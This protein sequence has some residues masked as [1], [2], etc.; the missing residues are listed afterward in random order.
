[1]GNRAPVHRTTQKCSIYVPGVCPNNA[2]RMPIHAPLPS[3]REVV[4]ALGM[5]RLKS[6]PSTL[7][8]PHPEAA[9]NV[10]GHVCS[11]NG[12]ETHVLRNPADEG[13]VGCGPPPSYP[14][15]P[16]RGFQLAR[17]TPPAGF[18][19]ISQHRTGFPV[20]CDMC[21]TYTAGPNSRTK[22]R[23]TITRNY[24]PADPDPDGSG[25]RP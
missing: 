11:S 14:C 5:R 6:R 4:F 20:H 13:C 8:P 12:R 23:N 19:K 21:T 17:S 16:A 1:M 22:T 25:V 2:A 15:S 24:V 18:L 7:L 9:G 10:L 3:D